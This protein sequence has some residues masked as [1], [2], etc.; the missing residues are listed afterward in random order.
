MAWWLLCHPAAQL[1]S[2]VVGVDLIVSW[3]D[4]GGPRETQTQHRSYPRLE[5]KQRPIGRSHRRHQIIKV[6]ILRS[7]KGRLQLTL[8]G[9]R[10]QDIRPCNAEQVDWQR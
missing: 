8:S 3:S 6:L 5:P 1:V 2:R 10:P 9:N 4:F 7:A